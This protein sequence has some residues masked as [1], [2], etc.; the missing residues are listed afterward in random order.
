MYDFIYRKDAIFLQLLRS[1]KRKVRMNNP[2]PLIDL[3]ARDMEFVKTP[4]F[5]TQQ[6]GSKSSAA[7]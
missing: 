6:I 2:D 4:T 7:N 3:V 1:D 5:Q